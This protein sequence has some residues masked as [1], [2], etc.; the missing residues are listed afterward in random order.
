MQLDINLP[1]AL[2]IEDVQSLLASGDDGQDN[3]LRVDRSG[4]AYLSQVTGADEL[5]GVLFRFPTWDAGNGY[6]GAEAARDVEWV[7]KILEA[8]QRNWSNPTF[9]YIDTF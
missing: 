2:S 8:L 5:E 4:R 1:D 6:V 3:Q 7:K 9:S